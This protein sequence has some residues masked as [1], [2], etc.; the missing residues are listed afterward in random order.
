MTCHLSR[1]GHELLD[2]NRIRVRD[3]L[4]FFY[5]IFILPFAAFLWLVGE[6]WEQLANAQTLASRIGG[7]V[8]ILAFVFGVAVIVTV[9]A[10]LWK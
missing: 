1:P 2:P 9:F 6:L 3:V 7:I 5:C 8:T 4:C 10:E